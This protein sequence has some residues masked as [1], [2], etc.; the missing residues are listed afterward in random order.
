MD[1]Q[2]TTVSVYVDV[3][4]AIDRRLYYPAGLLIYRPSS[5][6]SRSS[7]LIALLLLIG[8]VEPNQGLQRQKTINLGL[9]NARSAVKK[10]SLIHDVITDHRLDIAV[11]TESWITS[12]AP[13]LDIAPAGYRVVHGHRGTSLDGRGGG[14]AVIYRDTIDQTVWCF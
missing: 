9:L 7:S 4:P 1:D 2:L 12:D 3:S 13:K 11:I 14:I 6:H 10:A 5:C 8:N